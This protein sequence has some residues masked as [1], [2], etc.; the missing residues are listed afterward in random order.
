MDILCLAFFLIQ[1]YRNCQ[2]FVTH[3]QTLSFF[4]TKQTIRAKPNKNCLTCRFFDS[5]ALGWTRVKTGWG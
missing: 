2:Y 4:L 3:T 5:I 1:A